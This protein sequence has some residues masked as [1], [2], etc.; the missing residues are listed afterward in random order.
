M[1][2]PTNDRAPDLASDGVAVDHELRDPA[3][4]VVARAVRHSL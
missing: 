2:P 4:D 3:V 1:T